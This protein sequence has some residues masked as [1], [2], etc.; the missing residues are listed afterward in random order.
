MSIA[1]GLKHRP[2]YVR[3]VFHLSLRLINYGGRSAQ[4]AYRVH[5]SGIKPQYLHFYFRLC[6]LFWNFIQIRLTL[7]HSL[8]GILYL[9]FIWFQMGRLSL[10]R[11]TIY[12]PCP[13]PELVHVRNRSSFLSESIIQL[14]ERTDVHAEN[15][16]A[17]HPTYTPESVP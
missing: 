12:V 4:L 15:R 17:L 6:P 9:Q 7:L 16:A 13:S 3:R 2:G 14:R 10:Q 1:P 11:S 8:F 5:K